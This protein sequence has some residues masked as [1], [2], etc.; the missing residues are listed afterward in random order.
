MA[1]KDKSK[2]TAS[3]SVKAF[4]RALEL[5]LDSFLRVH[6]KESWPAWFKTCTAYGGQEDAKNIWR[7][8]FTGVPSSVLGPGE[9]WEEAP[10]GYV[11]V[12]TD[13]ESKERRYIIS[14]AAR[15]VVVIFEA[16]VDLFSGNVTIL[17]D[18]DL[19]SIDGRVLL[20]LRK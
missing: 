14:N 9:S 17:S 7:F 15:E 10:N 2:E 12:K 18:M 13:P 16:T 11:L 20:P 1:T 19:A 5:F 8:S 4:D 3:D 6:P